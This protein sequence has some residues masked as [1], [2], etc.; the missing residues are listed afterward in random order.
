MH[1][2]LV[3]NVAHYR[4]VAIELNLLRGKP[5]ENRQMLSRGVGGRPSSRHNRETKEALE[6]KDRWRLWCTT[7]AL[8][9]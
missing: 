6:G 9:D 7:T 8:K 3:E 2:Q 4:D 5:Y 1:L